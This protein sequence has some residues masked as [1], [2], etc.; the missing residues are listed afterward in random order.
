LF[1]EV[2]R[3]MDVLSISYVFLPQGFESVEMV[4]QANRDL[5]RL[6]LIVDIV[7]VLPNQVHIA[8]EDLALIINET[9]ALTTTA[10]I[11]NVDVADLKST[12]K[13]GNVALIG[14]GDA[15][16]EDRLKE[17][18]RR[19][20]SHRLMLIDFPAVNNAVINVSGGEDMTIDEAEGASRWLA[21]LIRDDAK[22]VWG[23][24]VNDSMGGRLRVF[25]MA[26]ATPME[27]L[28][29]IYTRE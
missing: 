13:G 19:S 28:M 25:V 15:E 7:A 5:H 26:A 3:E 16:G 9:I 22:I 2:T 21:K 20:L 10:G 27:V 12:V 17:A 18:V 4:Q 1:A 24:D 23:A 8:P 11:V 6:R 29:Y 14:I